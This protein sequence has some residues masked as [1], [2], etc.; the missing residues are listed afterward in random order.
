MYELSITECTMHKQ[1]VQIVVTCV[2]VLEKFA[3]FLCWIDRSQ[4]FLSNNL[5]V[6]FRHHPKSVPQCNLSFWQE[7]LSDNYSH[8]LSFVIQKCVGEVLLQ[9][10]S[11]LIHFHYL[12]V[13]RYEYVWCVLITL[14]KFSTDWWDICSL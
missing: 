3:L 6:E 8:S 11:T 4:K 12:Q 1:N 13:F 5:M 9:I 2:A 10:K 7:F 14:A